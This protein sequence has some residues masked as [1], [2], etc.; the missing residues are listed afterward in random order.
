MHRFLALVAAAC[1]IP[2]LAAV[3]VNT[4]QQSE[5][6]RTKGLDRATAKSIIDYRDQTGTVFTSPEDLE[7]VP[8]LDKADMNKLAPQITFEGPPYVPPPKPE[9]KAKGKDAR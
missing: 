7:K 9:K 4:A 2:A 3:N 6:E 5:L 8:G 1:A